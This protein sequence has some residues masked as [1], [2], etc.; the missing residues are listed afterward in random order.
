M[1]NRSVFRRVWFGVALGAAALLAWSVPQPARAYVEVPMSLGDVVRQSTNI[2]QMQVTKVDREKNLIIYTKLQDI[3]GKHPQTE[4]KHNIG[5]GGLRPG[6]WEEIMK[7][8]EVGKV[9]TFFHNGGASETYFGTSWYQAYPQ[10]EWWGMSHGE[11]FLLRSYAG[12]VDKLPGVL[13]DMLADKEVIVPCMVDG[14]KEAIHKKT[15]RIQRL[16]ASL[17]LVDYNPKR[18]FVGWGGEDIRRLQ[19]VPGFDRY[20]A[21]SK[22][23][24]EAQ[25]VT[26]VDFD[27]DG[28]PDICL[29][30]ANK[31]VLLQ[32]GGD[33]FIEVALPGLTGGARAA[34][35]ADCNGDGLPDLLL[36]TPTGPR[37]Y[38]NL[39]K[40]QF[41]DETRRLPRELAYNLTAAAWGDIDGDGKPDI[42]LANGFHGLRVYQNV[43]PE[44]PKIV[45]PQVGEWQAIGIF[46]A[47]NPAD[48]FKTAFPV[49]SDKFTPQKEYKGKRNLPTKWA[50][51]D[52]PPGQPTPLPEMG[53]NCATYMRTELDMPADAEVPVSIGTGGNTLTVWVNDE[54]VYGEEKGKPEPTAL[55]LKLKR[56]KNTL[57]VKMCNAELPQV[58]SF[59]VGTGDSGPPGPWF[60]DVSTAW[61]FGPDGLCADTK[62]DTLA[63]ADFTG[64]GKPDMLYGAGTGVL[65]VNQGG[66]FAIKPDCGISYKPGKVGPAVCDFD[67]DGHLDLFIPQANGRC[68]LLRNNGTGTFTDVAADAGD[69]ARG[70]P[71]AV[72]AAWG[73]FDNDGRPDLLVCCLKGPNRYFKN[74]GGGKF[75]ERT[76]ELGLGQKV[77]NSQ[78]AAFADLNGDG[79][80]DLILAN[81]GQESCVL[82]GVQTPGGA[83]TPVT[84]ALNGTISLNG[85]KVVVKDTT[86]ARVACS[87]VCG[88]DG[89]GGQSGLSP[90]FV[91]APGAYTFE[92]IGSDGKATVKDVTVTATP[93][94]VK[95]Q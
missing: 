55:D 29:V 5:R 59:A 66:T 30:G 90:R 78:A 45:L 91:L 61:G 25:S 34:V 31:V 6:E 80:L 86:G 19:G 15:A 40:A 53:A 24:A 84:V 82:F 63:V 81:E 58:F 56:G 52:V 13:A 87:A 9:A 2:V 21:L 33:G 71:N 85:G 69:L 79:Q 76:K 57:L 18:D 93:M 68:Q 75:V 7:W 49:E 51:K 89:R 26:T 77:F 72:S 64:D 65:L 17:K 44:A 41:R 47:Q 88:G 23:E 36:A 37:L 43:R 67:G 20:A 54:K 62:G 73:D 32:N 95:A 3:K 16:K 74:E 48:N 83:K 46:R 14:D 60:R 70:V 39:G 50:K 12:K 27:N 8:A 92:L 42:V 11:P 35:W 94:Q 1:S 22:L 38:V 4:I 28:K 10:G